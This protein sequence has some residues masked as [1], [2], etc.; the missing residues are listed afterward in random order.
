[1]KILYFIYMFFL[2]FNDC[3]ARG[4]ELYT[5]SLY[6]NIGYLTTPAAYIHDG[7]V[8]FHYSYIPH[9]VA[10]N[11]GDMYKVDTDNWIFSSSLGFFPF[12][13]FYFSVFVEPQRNVSVGIPN[14]GANKFRSAGAKFK[15]NKESK[16]IPSVAIGLFDPN[17]KKFGSEK[18]ANTVSSTFIVL[19]KHF[20]SNNNSF[21]IGYGSDILSGQ[22][23]RLDGIFGGTS[24]SLGHKLFLMCDYDS[25]YWSQGVGIIWKNINLEGALIDFEYIAFRLGYDIDLLAPQ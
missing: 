22:F 19:S 10:V 23:T 21:S 3:L 16:T 7:E 6:S 5:K 2:L 15:I 17:L 4:E 1:M 11:S 14:F 13:E 24:F 25:K 12:L 8:S 20:F 18:S 9:P